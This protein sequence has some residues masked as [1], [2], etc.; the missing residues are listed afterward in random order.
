MKT[1]SGNWNVYELDGIS[2]PQVKSLL[3]FVA[4]INKHAAEALASN[5]LSIEKP[6]S[7]RAYYVEA[8]FFGATL[9]PSGVDY[10]ARQ[11]L[12]SAV[13][14][15]PASRKAD[16]LDCLDR[17]Y[18]GGAALPD[19]Y[20]ATEGVM[21]SVRAWE[22]LTD[23]HHFHSFFLTKDVIKDDI[24]DIGL[25]IRA[26]LKKHD[27]EQVYEVVALDEGAH[28]E[29]FIAVLPLRP[30]SPSAQTPKAGAGPVT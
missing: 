26:A 6:D 8:L 3:D 24:R 16:F 27:L 11:F 9:A 1:A 30:K 4:D 22:A 2:A 5:I 19:A 23:I 15:I 20:K 25:C 12:Q 7:N 18:C 13:G 10:M 17:Y 14:Q 29:D 28:P 21:E